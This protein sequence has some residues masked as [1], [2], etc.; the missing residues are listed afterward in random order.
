MHAKIARE[1]SPRLGSRRNGP[2]LIN[3]RIASCFDGP[4]SL[5]KLDGS[6]LSV[7]LRGLPYRRPAA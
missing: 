4:S 1:R 6:R 3:T 5:E 7:Q 2:S